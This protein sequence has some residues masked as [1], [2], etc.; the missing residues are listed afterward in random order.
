M[1][2]SRTAPALYHVEPP[3][4]VGQLGP[5]SLR[6]YVLVALLGNIWYV[7]CGPSNP[8]NVCM[9]H[10]LEKHKVLLTVEST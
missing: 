3:P 1:V 4:K 5:S 9:S 7:T 2:G 10:H 8:C 6:V